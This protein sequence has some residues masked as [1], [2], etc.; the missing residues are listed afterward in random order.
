ME[1]RIN[2]YG[3]GDK[4]VPDGIVVKSHP[5]WSDRVEIAHGGGSFIVIAA[6]LLEAVRRCSR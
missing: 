5:T 4:F 2:E 3:D 1:A 6:D